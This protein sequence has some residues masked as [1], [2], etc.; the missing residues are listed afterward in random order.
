MLVIN[1]DPTYQFH[2]DMDNNILYVKIDKYISVDQFI[3]QFIPEY[4]R[5]VVA[6]HRRPYDYVLIIPNTWEVNITLMGEF[7]KWMRTCIEKYNLQ[8]IAAV[9]IIPEI[10]TLAKVVKESLEIDDSRVGVFTSL[11]E[12][13]T[14]LKEV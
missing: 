6:F 4:K 13:K 5:T 12:V 2:I 14:W 7:I 10:T 11:D 9:S 1:G 3:N 8:K